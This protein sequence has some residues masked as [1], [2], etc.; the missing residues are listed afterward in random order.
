MHRWTT[1]DITDIDALASTLPYCDIVVTDKAAASVVK[2]T[3]LAGRLQ[4]IVLSR[5]SDLAQRL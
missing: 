4:T 3:G 2:V 1:N 5:L